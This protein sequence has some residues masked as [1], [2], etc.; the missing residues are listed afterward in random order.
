MAKPK[1]LL[2]NPIDPSGVRILEEVA[3]VVTAPDARAATLRHMI[4]DADALIVRAHLPADIFD[5]PHHLRG[6]VRH[7]VGLD[8]IP[9]DTATRQAIPVANVPAVNAEAVAEYCISGMLLLARRMH[10]LD[11]DLRALDWMTSRKLSDDATE[12]FG[13]TVGVIGVGNVG[14]RVAEICHAGFRMRVL[15]NQRRLN[16][17]PGF[18][19]GV[20]VDT[21]FRESDFIV[22]NCPLTAET[23]NLVNPSRISLMKR[24]TCIVNASRGQV[25]DEPALAAALRDKRI[26]GAVLDVFCEQPLRRDHPFLALENVILTPHAAGIT[27]ES[28]QRMSQGAAQ[29]IVR[30]L[31]DERPVN[32]VNPEIWDQYLARRRAAS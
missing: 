17:L 14:R 1:V 23:T 15:G 4:G 11:R 19:T 22:L 27:Q 20:D 6:V 16:A 30:L 8:M 26:G 25:I 5:R 18:V 29:E 24:T 10:R 3:D 12:L 31:A 13:R 9:V 32:L 2:T 21:V 28:M 7:G